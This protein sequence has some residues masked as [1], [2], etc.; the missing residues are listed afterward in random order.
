MANAVFTHSE[1]SRYDDRPEVRYHFPRTYLNQA[2]KAVGEL[3]VYY[4]PRRTEGPDST[5]GRQA[6]FAVAR[7]RAIEPDPVN[8]DH[9][10]A[11]LDEYLEF[12]RAVPFREGGRTYETGL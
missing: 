1:S 10:Y 5:T 3:I 7:L 8:A 12:D 11:H 4:E 6:Y 2:T 9:F